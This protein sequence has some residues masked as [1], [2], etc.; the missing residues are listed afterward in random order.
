V[1]VSGFFAFFD[2]AYV[3]PFATVGQAVIRGAGDWI[4][5]EGAGEVRGLGH[6]TRFGIE[7]QLHL[8]LVADLH[9][10]GSTVGVTEA[11]K[12]ASTH[13]GDPALP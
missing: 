6:D 5:A 3:L 8:D 9:T 7:F 4:D 1:R 11:K 13:D 10:C 12:E 2:S